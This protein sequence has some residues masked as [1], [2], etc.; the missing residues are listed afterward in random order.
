MA[1]AARDGLVA[2]HFGHAREF[3]VYEASASGARLVGH[4]KAESYCSGDESCGDAESVLERTIKALADCEVVLCSQDRLRALGQ[5][6]SGRHP[7]QWRTR[8]GAD[9]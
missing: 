8:H 9:R 5:S 2:V 4:R 3:L 6:R 1:V 7:A